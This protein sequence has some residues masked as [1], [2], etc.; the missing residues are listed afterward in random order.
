MLPF[1]CYR[2]RR[3][4]H[5]FG[6]IFPNQNLPWHTLAPSV[7]SSCNPTSRKVAQLSN[8][9]VGAARL[10]PVE[11][12]WYLADEW[13]QHNATSKWLWLWQPIG[14]F[15]T[16]T[17]RL[18]SFTAPFRGNIRGETGLRELA[19]V[20]RRSRQRYGQVA[21]KNGVIRNSMC[22]IDGARQLK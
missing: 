16:I 10:I 5:C 18:D 1:V 9:A 19:P 17:R 7:W 3:H 14:K 4:V 20:S 2:N 11:R 15:T 13:M 22:E 12:W 6:T 21:D 8:E